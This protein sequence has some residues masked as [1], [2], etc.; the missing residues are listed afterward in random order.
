MS[1]RRGGG[2][3]VRHADHEADHSLSALA[4]AESLV[5]RPTGGR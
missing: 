3:G 2:N 5:V 4:R 1:G